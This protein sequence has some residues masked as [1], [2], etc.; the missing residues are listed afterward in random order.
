MRAFEVTATTHEATRPLSNDQG[1][2]L[3]ICV[4]SFY[5]NLLG[6]LDNL[7]WASTFELRLLEN[8]DEDDWDTRRFC[9]LTSDDFRSSI[10]DVRPSIGV[11]IARMQDWLREVK[12]FRDPATHRLPLSIVP[13]VMS[14]VEEAQYLDLQR[15]AWQ[16]MGEHRIEE[17]EE[18][19]EVA[20]TVGCFVPYLDGPLALDG[21]YVVAPQLMAED[22]RKFLDFVHQWVGEMRKPPL[23]TST[24]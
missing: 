24:R 17:A 6:A 3:N 7:A 16:L 13:G 4:N 18:L 20:A 11:L 15:R 23:A 9:S 14:D 2:L 12:R 21:S 19:F 22:Q 1:N 5:V 10:S 8:P